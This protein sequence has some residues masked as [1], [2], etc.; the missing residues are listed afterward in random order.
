MSLLSKVAS[1]SHINLLQQ[2]HPI[3]NVARGILNVSPLRFCDHCQYSDKKENINILLKR[4]AV[5]L[6]SIQR[7]EVRNN[8]SILFVLIFQ[9]PFSVFLAKILRNL[10]C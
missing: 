1:L 2:G 7:I 5:N 3:S 8:K 9:N 10:S 4:K 6:T